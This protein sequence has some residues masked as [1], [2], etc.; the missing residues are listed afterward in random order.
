MRQLPRLQPDPVGRS[1]WFN[2]TLLAV[3]FFSVCILSIETVV[4]YCHWG[5]WVVLFLVGCQSPVSTIF[6][7]CVTQTVGA[8][9]GC[10]LT[11]T[12]LFIVTW[13]VRNTLWIVEGRFITE[14]RVFLPLFLPL[15]LWSLIT[16]TMLTTTTFV[17]QLLLGGFTSIIALKEMHGKRASIL[18]IAVGISLAGVMAALPFWLSKIGLNFFLAERLER[19]IHIGVMRGGLERFAGG[20]GDYN[21][22]GA[23]M[24]IGMAGLIHLAFFSM[25]VRTTRQRLAKWGCQALVVIIIPSV[26]ATLSRASVLGIAVGC[27]V[28]FGVHYFSCRG[29]GFGKV[30]R[31]TLRGII[32][33]LVVVGAVML[34]ASQDVS[35]YW[36]ALM[37]FQA[38]RHLGMLDNRAAQFFRAIEGIMSSPIFGC[39]TPRNVYGTHNVFLDVAS[40]CGVPGLCLFCLFCFWP[41]VYFIRSGVPLEWGV[42]GS[43]YLMTLYSMLSLSIMGFKFFWVLWAVVLWG[44]YSRVA[45]SSMVTVRPFIRVN[46]GNRP[47]EPSHI[48]S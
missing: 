7:L 5:V 44:A 21:F 37:R 6:L 38:S 9:P 16:A 28:P 43:L 48:P 42:F 39:F 45:D 41:V 1:S 4:P 29:R 46:R 32:L 19:L 2:G 30:F 36:E 25:T 3:C 15:F 12:Q 20:Q 27:V 26:L 8:P 17:T 24:V 47:G 14:L 33:M 35:R 11:L 40:Y 23:C 18:G 31:D 13:V 10:P 34:F 22:L